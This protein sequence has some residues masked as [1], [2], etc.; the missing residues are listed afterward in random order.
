MKFIFTKTDANEWVHVT[1]IGDYT[2]IFDEE[3]DVFVLYFLP[4]RAGSTFKRLNVH[5]DMGGVQSEA[6][7][8]YNAL[9]GGDHAIR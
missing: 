3:N 5:M 9:K 2:V 7:R 6:Q 1:D 4:S 8:H